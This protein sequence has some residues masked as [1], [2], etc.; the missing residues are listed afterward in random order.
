MKFLKELTPDYPIVSGQ[1]FIGP[2]D[3]IFYIRSVGPTS[4]LIVTEDGIAT[5]SNDYIRD[6]YL[7]EQRPEL[8][9]EGQRGLLK[10]PTLQRVIL[11]GAYKL[12]DNTLHTKAQ[13]VITGA[14]LTIPVTDLYILPP[15]TGA[16]PY[17]AG[18][19]D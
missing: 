6:G 18:P 5:C 10:K 11:S 17:F 3:E 13:V 14:E 15:N 1:W 4:S 2:K 12:I 16:L 19:T 8:P 9:V 7:I